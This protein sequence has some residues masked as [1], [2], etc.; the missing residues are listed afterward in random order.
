MLVEPAN[1]VRLVVVQIRKIGMGKHPTKALFGF[2]EK[3]HIIPRRKRTVLGGLAAT[4][5]QAPA[6]SDRHKIV[7][8]P[9]NP[10][11]T[12]IAKAWDIGGFDYLPTVITSDNTVRILWIEYFQCPCLV[13]FYFF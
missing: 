6:L 12:A 9:Q 8:L 5:D 13:V 10:L 1:L 4:E 3:R 11:T 7:E 2:D